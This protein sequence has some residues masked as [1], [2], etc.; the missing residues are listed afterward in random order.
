MLGR[1]IFIKTNES[2][3]EIPSGL[4]DGVNTSFTIVNTPKVGTFN[5]YLNGVKQ[6]LNTHYTISGVNLTLTSAPL[7]GDIITCSYIYH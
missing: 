2:L 3:D 5:L 1:V 7:A 6:Y 4:I